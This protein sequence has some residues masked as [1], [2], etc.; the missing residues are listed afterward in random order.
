MILHH[1][2][3]VLCNACSFNVK[4]V[5]L[6]YQLHLQRPSTP[7]PLQT[8]LY[9]STC[10]CGRRRILH[11]VLAWSCI[12]GFMPPLMQSVASLPHYGVCMARDGSAR[13]AARLLPCAVVP[14]RTERFPLALSR[15]VPAPVLTLQGISSRMLPCSTGS[16]TARRPIS[17]AVSSPT[18]F[19]VASM[20]AT[21]ASPTRRSGALRHAPLAASYLLLTAQLAKKAPEKIDIGA[22]Y[23]VSPA[24]HARVERFE[25]QEKELVFDIDA[26][27][28]IRHLTCM[29]L[30]C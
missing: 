15:L 4:V 21:S 28:T 11:T 17:H 20:P 14:C 27:Y 8:R 2:L 18:R 6:R 7:S 9:S 22:V 23:N 24:H 12:G 1:F 26:R 30:T 13:H 25:A 19:R 5:K 10:G 3:T 29:A 16:R